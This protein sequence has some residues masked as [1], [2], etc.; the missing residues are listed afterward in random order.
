MDSSAPSSTYRGYRHQALYTLYRLFTDQDA[1]NR[2]YCPEGTEDLDICDLD[3]KPLEMIQVKSYAAQL[4]LSDFSPDKAS[5]YFYRVHRNAIAN[6]TGT[7][8]LV[9]YGPLG[10]ELDAAFKGS[11]TSRRDVAKK[12]VRHSTDLAVKFK[13]TGLRL[14][15]Q[16]VEDTLKRISSHCVN[17]STITQQLIERI[18][19]TMMGA[20]PETTLELLLWWVFRAAE[21]RQSLVRESIQRKAK[22]IG[23]TL[24]RVQSHFQEWE[25]S[26]IGLPSLSIPMERQAIL[27]EEF[28]RGRSATWEHIFAGVDAPRPD[29]LNEIHDKLHRNNVVIIHGASGQ[30][31][32][33]LGYRYMLDFCPEPWRF[34]VRAVVSRE[35]ALNIAT[36]I[37]SHSKALGVP[38]VVFLDVAPNDIGWGELV[39]QLAQN[40]QIK[41]L[42]A[43][44]EEDYRRVRMDFAG[45][46]VDQ[47]DLDGVRKEEAAQIFTALTAVSPAS[48]VLN[49]EDA[50]RRFGE[51]KPL[52]EFTY[53]V[54]QGESLREKLHTQIRALQDE[55]KRTD[56][57]ITPQHLK[58]LAMVSV[59]SA[60]ECRLNAGKLCD[61][62]VLSP[63][64]NPFDS[65]EREYLI[66][67]SEEVG[68]VGGLH[69]I[70]SQ[71][72]LEALLGIT[73]ELWGELAAACI[74]LLLESDIEPFLLRVFSRR[75]EEARRI[76]DTVK[77]LGTVS[78]EQAGG[79]TRTLLWYGASEYE[80]TNRESIKQA[81][82]KF[83]GAW[84][85]VFDGFIAELD[86]KTSTLTRDT[87]RN[88]RPDSG[89]TFD[90][91]KQ[92]HKANVFVPLRDWLTQSKQDVIPPRT[93]EDWLGLGM[94]AFWIGRLSMNGKWK[95]TLETVDYDMAPKTLTIAELG[96][97]AMGLWQSGSPRFLKWH[98]DNCA[99]L[100]S[101]FLNESDSLTLE[102]SNGRGSVT[103][104]VELSRTGEKGHSHDTLNQQAMERLNVVRTLFPGIA[105][106][107]SQGLGLAGLPF[108][109][110]SDPTS[111]E[112]PAENLPLE[113]LVELNSTFRCLVEVR[114][115]RPKDW[116]D[117]L[118]TVMDT[119]NQW[120]GTLRALVKLLSNIMESHN[121]EMAWQAQPAIEYVCQSAVKQLDQP[122][123]PQCA[124]DE[125]GFASDTR[126]KEVPSVSPVNSPHA[127]ALSQFRRYHRATRDFSGSFGTFLN[128][129]GEAT[130]LCLALRKT[131]GDEN[132]AAALFE[133]ELALESS[134][135][136]RNLCLLNLGD[137]V[138]KLPGFQR[139]FRLLFGFR[140]KLGQLSELERDEGRSIARAWA[141]CFQFCLNPAKVF[142]DP[143][144][145]ALATVRD[146]RERF[147]KILRRNLETLS[148][149]GLKTAL[150]SERATWKDEG[151]LWITSDTNEAKVTETLLDHVAT[152]IFSAVTECGFANLESL[153]LQAEW[154]YI[155]IVPQFRGR[156]LTRSAYGI[157][158]IHFFAANPSG[159]LPEVYR[160]ALEPVAEEQ[161]QVVNP[162][163][164]AA[165][166]AP[167][168]SQWLD[169][170]FTFLFQLDG[171]IH[172]FAAA[173][174]H[175]DLLDSLENRAAVWSKSLS[176]WENESYEA[177]TRLKEFVRIRLDSRLAN[178][179]N[180]E[181][182]FTRLT[183]WG[184]AVYP[185]ER[186]ETRIIVDPEKY[187]QWLSSVQTV[188]PKLR[189]IL[190][191]LIENFLWDEPLP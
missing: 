34:Q 73:S 136:C 113:P 190:A 112:I 189:E 38:A 98:Q 64:T 5:C 41:I 147:L 60:Y 119:R 32:S 168:A 39:R 8:C 129:F 52:M 159:R 3:G 130:H 167:L 107:A 79:I 82:E 114:H 87:L 151:A 111:K 86:N 118:K 188:L 55:A 121:N 109:Q 140:L 61:Y 164:W 25:R 181:A 173:K 123:L 63:L 59:A 23:E 125:W 105:T 175:P 26:I 138:E 115:R 178:I 137:A 10:A 20:V 128:Q 133:S 177:Y 120:A 116:N 187:F 95:D 127:N 58:L 2:I 186:S 170:T 22:E 50:W 135:K 66:L 174:Q 24:A 176:K 9:S 31:K 27:T 117:Y 75:P 30:G 158:S 33:T 126:A 70:R 18:R 124:V 90:V 156:S 7:F 77:S 36:A 13:D 53:F 35:H 148:S 97:V 29:R 134:K 40:Q 6:P 94:V 83:D 141:V 143:T 149:K 182:I 48:H 157:H 92:T 71:F 132:A 165:P 62:L 166:I 161:W 85:L 16:E 150:L 12:L 88:I 15:Q 172:L 102:I 84:W 146:K 14:K 104:L 179:S 45:I 81:I 42:I 144:A 47:I 93:A 110:G 185:Q 169:K 155:V 51:N 96:H 78:W 100:R 28:R 103:F 56:G 4:T 171:L 46:G 43:S 1:P 80:K 67:R 91:C 57:R 131:E 183:E 69:P 37:D 68:A 54:S 74:P 162:P 49:F 142:V 19:T 11:I 89:S 184:K 153:P 17:E 139:E 145:D 101:R 163:L 21:E 180:G 122:E 44:R 160:F 154:K 108:W 76:V 65:F 191:D 152:A 106:Y 72:V 99:L